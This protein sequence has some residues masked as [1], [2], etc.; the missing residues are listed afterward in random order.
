MCFTICLFCGAGHEVSR[1]AVSRFIKKSIPK[2]GQ[3]ADFFDMTRHNLACSD[4]KTRR[5]LVKR[6]ET[7]LEE[8][9][10][11]KVS[12]TV[13]TECWMLRHQLLRP[14]ATC[15]VTHSAD[16]KFHLDFPA[17]LRRD[18]SPGEESHEQSLELPSRTFSKADSIFLGSAAR[19]LPS[20]VCRSAV[21]RSLLFS[22]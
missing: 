8:V 16:Q 22:L 15:E 11:Q 4:V 19:T 14:Q 21:R 20:A 3:N 7:T 18:F 6:G 13:D 10:R 1:G 9:E 5:T 2:N 17:G 12:D